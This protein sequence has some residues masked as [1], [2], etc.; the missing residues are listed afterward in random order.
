M[1]GVKYDEIKFKLK[2]IIVV[3]SGKSNKRTNS[4]FESFW[5]L[6]FFLVFWGYRISQG[7]GKER[8][9]VKT[10]PPQEKKLVKMKQIRVYPIEI[11]YN[12]MNLLT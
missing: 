2:I 7:E 4:C 8:G 11:F 1:S 5:V 12:I 9:G 3:S 10:G 6:K